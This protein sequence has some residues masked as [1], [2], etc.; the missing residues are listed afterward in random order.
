ML[1]SSQR[2]LDEV[3][4]SAFLAYAL[5]R[6]DRQ[7]FLDDLLLGD[8]THKSDVVFPTDGK[9]L[10][11]EHD[12]VYWHPEERDDFTKTRKLLDVPNAV[13]VRARIGATEIPV[14]HPRLVQLLLPGNA[15]HMD[16]LHA[17]VKAVQPYVARELVLPDAATQKQLRSFANTVFREIHPDYDTRVAQRAEWLREHGLDIDPTRFVGVPLGTLQANAAVLK[18][19]LGL[20]PAKIATHANLLSCGPAR[21]QANAAVLKNTLGLTPAKIATNAHLLAR[22]PTTLQ[23]NAS[24]LKNTLGLTP[25][26]IATNAHLL[27]RDPTTLQAN[28]SVLKNTLGLTPAKIATNAHLLSCDPARLQ[29][30]AEIL[31]NTLGIT[32]AKI[33]TN[34]H[35]LSNDPARLQANAAV[36]KNTLGITSAK[37][38][39]NA[40]LLARDPTTLQANAV[41]LDAHNFEWRNDIATLSMSPSRMKAALQFLTQ[42][43]AIPRSCIRK[44]HVRRFRMALIG[45]A[46]FMEMTQRAKLRT[47]MRRC[48]I[49]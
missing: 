45:D 18:N 29:D 4:H 9:L 49:L 10:V 14:S 11:Y 31:K 12:P 38:A 36:L 42:D 35:L 16:V 7:T 24:V 37:I 26:K 23:A 34:A 17:F 1:P 27:A 22:D 33:A 44:N 3:E 43:C 25:A 2:S 28:A 41:W 15:K 48:A 46:R 30:K 5:G 32:P 47:I 19:T 8:R 21:L 13:V 20:T 39:T 6:S 40:H